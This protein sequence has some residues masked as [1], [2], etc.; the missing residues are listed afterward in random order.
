[1]GVYEVKKHLIS[2]DSGISIN[3]Q[4]CLLNMSKGVFYC[5]RKAE[6]AEN[7]EMMRLMDQHITEDPTAGVLTMQAML[8]ENGYESG[9]EKVR[10]L[11][12]LADIFPIYPRKHLT[13]LGEKKYIH[14][15][16]LKNLQIERP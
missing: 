16:L 2:K 1:M 9:Y 15:Y 5:V 8:E 11:M 12:R 14:P 3:H 13:V 10:R 4:L 7:L 6:S